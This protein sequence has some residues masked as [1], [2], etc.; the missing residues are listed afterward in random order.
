M[1]RKCGELM[2]AALPPG[3]GIM[4]SISGLNKSVIEE[5]CLKYS[6]ENAPVVIS[7]YN[8]PDQIV[9]SGHQNSVII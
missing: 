2:A 1:V 4:C 5:K 9:I 6:D 3:K 8:S 7:N